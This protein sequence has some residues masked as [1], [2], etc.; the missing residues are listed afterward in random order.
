MQHIVLK[1][2]A[3]STLVFKSLYYCCCPSINFRFFR[4]QVHKNSYRLLYNLE[5][6]R[7]P[8]ISF[9][10][11]L[12]NQNHVTFNVDANIFVFQYITNDGSGQSILQFSPQSSRCLIV[13]I[14]NNCFRGN[15]HILYSHILIISFLVQP[16][17]S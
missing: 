16:Y 6:L 7:H 14:F 9:P 12:E 3:T 13:I 10:I 1:S 8:K 17:C 2:I 5:K 4:F 11:V 15:Q